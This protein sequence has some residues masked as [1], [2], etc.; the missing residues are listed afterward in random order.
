[1]DLTT[2]AT[3]FAVVLLAELPDK[4]LLATLVLATRYRARW[5]WLGVSAAFLVH[6]VIACAAG[7]LLT[8]APRRLVE[9]VVAVLFAVAAY[10]LLRPE[11]A[12]EPAEEEVPV[13]PSPR[14]WPVLATSFGFVFVGEWGDVTQLATANLVARYE[15][16]VSV[17][18][19]AALGLLTAAALAVTAGQWLLRHVPLQLVRRCA[20]LLMA[21][22]A[23]LAVVAVLR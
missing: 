2:T 8:L 22:F 7:R 9:V 12:D 15:D 1:M 11:P 10:L 19:G 23:A 21:V 14:L 4:S 5:V 18:V 13:P 3:V 20:G 16:V 6:V 17:G